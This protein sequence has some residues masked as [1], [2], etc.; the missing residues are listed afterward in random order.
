MREII[1]TRRPRKIALSLAG[2]ALALAGTAQA[3]PCWDNGTVSAGRLIEL[4]T[5]FLVSSLRCKAIGVDFRDS[6]ESFA[7][8]YKH[9]F[10]TAQHT[11]MAHFDR[12]GADGRGDYQ[13]Y[14]T[15]LA[16]FYGAG[17][18]DA[19]TCHGFEALNR[20]LG[21]AAANPD[22]LG[23][24]AAEMVRDPQIDGLICPPAAIASLNVERRAP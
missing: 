4:E 21:N 9:T 19:E 17:K 10:G 2:L 12:A 3:S 6:N 5:M 13:R 24:I 1:M 15:G 23:M 20:E 18:T 22:V 14:L 8:A 7:E 11:V 16:N